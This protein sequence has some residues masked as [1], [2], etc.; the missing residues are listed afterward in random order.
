MVDEPDLGKTDHGQ[1]HATHDG[2]TQFLPQHDADVLEP[3]FTQA[4]RAD[5]GNGGLGAGVTAGTH[6]HGDEGGQCHNLGQCIL[7]GGNDQAGEGGRHHQ[8]G[9]PGEAVLEKFPGGA[10]QVRL[11][12]GGHTTHQLHILGGLFRQDV[13]C[14]VEGNDTDHA[15]FGV[16]NGKA[17]EIVLTEHPGHRFLVGLGAHGD[18]IGGHD[19]LDTHLVIFGQQQVLDGHQTQQGP[20]VGSDIAGVDGFLI[21]ALTADAQ[22]GFLNGH[23]GPQGNVLGGHDGSGGVLGIPQDLVDGLAHFG[24]SG[25]QDPLDHVGRHFFNNVRCV[26]HVKFVQHLF[27]LVIGKALDEQFLSVRVHF[28][29]GFRCQFLGQQT[30]HQGDLAF[31]QIRKNLSDVGSI[32]G[33]QNISQRYVLLVLKHFDEGFLHDFKSFYHAFSSFS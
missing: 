17:E 10:L 27:Q 1:S 25:L 20:V 16:N 3:Q 19:L 28:D 8:N 9:Q 11:L 15:L 12:R 14:V 33:Y 30:V 22:D 7:E 24:V 4:Q 5:D 6:Q 13:H 29:E 26:V 31:F 2:G 32:H 21:H 18:D 23:I